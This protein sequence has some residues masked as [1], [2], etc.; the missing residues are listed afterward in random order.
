MRTSRGKRGTWLSVGW[1]LCAAAGC[2]VSGGTETGNPP[3]PHTGPALGECSWPAAL[4]ALDDTSREACRAAR[5]AVT[6]RQEDGSGATCLL[7]AQGEGCSQVTSD[8][9]ECES[10]CDPGEY[11]AA[12][13]GVGP[14]AVPEPPAGCRFAAALPAGVALH[15]CACE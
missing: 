2:S 15:C 11:V 5:S 7:D 12:C 9:E 6:C 3:W 10:L 13:G 14:G 8:P 4:L 1:L